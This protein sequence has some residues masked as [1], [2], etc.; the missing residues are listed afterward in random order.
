MYFCKGDSYKINKYDWKLKIFRIL[1]FKSWQLC[2]GSFIT[3]WMSRCLSYVMALLFLHVWI[4]LII[5]ETRQY[6]IFLCVQW[7]AFH[8]SS[9]CRKSR[10]IYL[11]GVI[12][13]WA[14]QT[15]Q[16][17]IRHEVISFLG[18]HISL[19]VTPG[20][21]IQY[22]MT[23]SSSLLREKTINERTAPRAPPTVLCSV[24][25]LRIITGATKLSNNFE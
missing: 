1:I 5:I 17:S 14:W 22:A 2:N 3:R 19:R 11:N 8:P 4:F 6:L 12:S 20:V 23:I 7:M 25:L 10:C 15:R 24:T 13:N 18:R 9:K 21:E 16:T